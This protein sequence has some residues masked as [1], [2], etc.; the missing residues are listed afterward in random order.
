MSFCYDIIFKVVAWKS[1]PQSFD[2]VPYITLI[3]NW[4]PIPIFTILSALHYLCF[5]SQKAPIS[6]KHTRRW[7]SLLSRRHTGSV[8]TSSADPHNAQGR[9]FHV[10]SQPRGICQIW[11]RL[12][13]SSTTFLTNVCL[14]GRAGAL[15]SRLKW[16]YL[17]KLSLWLSCWRVFCV[18]TCI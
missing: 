9:A 3:T 7:K 12:I 13:P 11:V 4:P 5:A 2:G 18:G 15:S 10:L 14:Q 17:A 16:L 8:H 6:V 1:L